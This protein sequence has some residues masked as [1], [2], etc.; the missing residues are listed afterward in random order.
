MVK[1]HLSC[2]GVTALKGLGE[3]ISK[4]AEISVSKLRHD[5]QDTRSGFIVSEQVLM[6]EMT[7]RQGPGTEHLAHYQ[8]G[9]LI[10]CQHSEG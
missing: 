9:Q 10:C 3:N 6:F 2:Q 4:K 8:T 7:K 5:N 1:S